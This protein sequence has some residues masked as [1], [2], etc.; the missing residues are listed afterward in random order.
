VSYEGDVAAPYTEGSGAGLS[1]SGSSSQD[2]RGISRQPNGAD[3]NRNNVDFARA[4]I[5][6]G[7]ANTTIESGCTMTGPVL[8]I[9]EIQGSGES[10]PY[11]GQTLGSNDNVVT[12]VGVDT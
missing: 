4:C 1:D 9:F 12:V 11:D 3:S 6:P 2:Y 8:E 5:T 10:S 7:A